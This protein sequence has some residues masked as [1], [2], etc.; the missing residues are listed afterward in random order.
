MP[1]ILV[2]YRNLHPK[3]ASLMR[4][5]TLHSEEVFVDGIGVQE[6]ME[7]GMIDRVV[8]T[9]GYLFMYFY[10]RVQ[11][12]DETGTHWHAPGRLI[13]WHPSDGHY[14]GSQEQPWKH[15]WIHL[16]GK[17]MPILL[18][19]SPIPRN[20]VLEFA[21]PEVFEKSLLSIYEEL[22]G[23]WPAD[24]VVIR[25]LTENLIRQVQRV[26]SNDPT[27][28]GV[29]RRMRAVKRHIDMHYN[30][31][32][33]LKSLAHIVHMSVS[34]LCSEFRA[35]FGCAPIEYRTRLRLHQACHFLTDYNL[36]VSE[37]ATRVGYS[38]VYYFSKHFKKRYGMSPS[39]LRRE[40]RESTSKASGS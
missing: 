20:L 39:K 15:S 11:I 37:V 3:A 12:Q 33:T 16:C 6:R 25:N 5:T 34:H 31:S 32:F 29:S 24:S 8:G 27:Q 7:P 22:E 28:E 21:Y 10:D 4:E 9:D 26:V 2:F 40:I 14:Y 17:E 36:Q 35:C 38:D 30:E 23:P 1:T 13:L 18:D 19:M